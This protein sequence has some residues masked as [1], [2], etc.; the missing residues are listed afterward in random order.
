MPTDYAAVLDQAGHDLNLQLPPTLQRLYAKYRCIGDLLTNGMATRA[1][2]AFASLIRDAELLGCKDY[3]HSDRCKTL[4]IP[5][6]EESLNPHPKRN[7]ADQLP[8][9]Q[10]WWLMAELDVQLSFLLGRRPCMVSFGNIPKP[11]ERHTGIDNDHDVFDLTE[12]MMGFL[13]R[14][15]QEQKASTEAPADQK[16]TLQADLKRLLHLQSTLPVLPLGGLADTRQCEMAQHQ[17]D[18]QLALTVVYTQLLRL[19]SAESTKPGR[20]LNLRKADTRIYYRDFLMCLRM[21]I[22]V[23]DYGHKLDSSKTSSSWARCFGVYCVASMLGIARLRHEVDVDT[24]SKRVETVLEIFKSLVDPKKPPGIAALASASLSE[25][26]KGIRGLDQDAGDSMV[27][28]AVPVPS[29]QKTTDG[30]IPQA[31][32][33][34]ASRPSPNVTAR[35]LKRTSSSILEEDVRYGKRQQHDQES[36]ADANIVESLPWRSDQV[37]PYPQAVLD[38]GVATSTSLQEPIASHSLEQHPFQ[39]NDFTPHTEQLEFFDIG[40]VPTHPDNFEEFHP[41]YHWTHPPFSYTVP[42]YDGWMQENM[43]PDATPLQ[44]SYHPPLALPAHELIPLDG[45]MDAYQE[46][47]SF[48]SEQQSSQSTAADMMMIS[49]KAL[50]SISSTPIMAHLPTEFQQSHASNAQNMAHG[51]ADI[52]MVSIGEPAIKL[53]DAFSTQMPSDQGTS[54][55]DLGQRQTNTFRID[56]TG[57]YSEQV[58]VFEASRHEK[59]DPNTQD[60]APSPRGDQ[61]VDGRLDSTTAAS[62]I[63]AQ[64]GQQY[65]ITR[66]E[67]SSIQSTGQSLCGDAQP[68]LDRDQQAQEAQD[69]RQGDSSPQ[70]MA[71]EDA[72]DYQNQ[73]HHPMRALTPVATTGPLSGGGLDWA[74]N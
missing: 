10:L 15:S 43:T 70:T 33:V 35:A 9:R 36:V 71:H 1:W 38:V 62:R 66:I 23:F 72:M 17:V 57:N 50:H 46:P 37:S 48:Y 47:G 29:E 53:E 42:M 19:M 55:A 65:S 14:G 6:V 13:N 61:D 40:Y 28:G 41:A 52:N 56:L 67:D 16:T 68:P 74:W 58:Q 45:A 12:Y 7:H 63:W 25:I 30:N 59:H 44:M 26:L 4:L 64:Q 5:A 51:T 39:A 34:G 73:F 31:S 3:Y 32:I 2:A 54:V 24:D 22:D 8:G 20:H 49:P 21:T 11:T 69:A 60:A 18:V 27:F